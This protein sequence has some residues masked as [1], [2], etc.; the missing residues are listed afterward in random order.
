MI[1]T[2]KRIIQ[3]VLAI[4]VV[5]TMTMAEFT[6]VGVNLISYAV[7]QVK[8]NNENVGF[9]VYFEDGNNALE[10]TSTI[11]KN[12][13]KVAIELNVKK[14]GYLSNGKI[15]LDE[16]SNFKFKADT[17]NSYISKVE[18]RAIYLKQIISCLKKSTL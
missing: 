15:V 3:K 18:D 14:D 1:I 13:L 16:G 9:N 10:T 2:G 17:K 5:L 6:M 12:D 11:D 7:D 8:I 4:L